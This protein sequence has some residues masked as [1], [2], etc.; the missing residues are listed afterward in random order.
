MLFPI[1]ETAETTIQPL[2]H[3]DTSATA[4]ATATACW[5]GVCACWWLLLFAVATVANMDAVGMRAASMAAVV[6][7]F[8]WVRHYQQQQLE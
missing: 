7:W 1:E 3:C 8:R 4:T 2:F 6:A 5:E